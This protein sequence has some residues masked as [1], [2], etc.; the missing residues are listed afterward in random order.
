MGVSFLQLLNNGIALSYS[1]SESPRRDQL[2]SG[3]DIF[4][5]LLLIEGF[6]IRIYSLVE[7]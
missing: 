6:L 7:K 3:E 1:G 4:Q 2:P 5:Y